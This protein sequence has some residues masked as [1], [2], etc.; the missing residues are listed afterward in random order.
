M[1]DKLRLGRINFKAYWI[2]VDKTAGVE[3][4]THLTGFI[5]GC[6][7]FISRR[8]LNCIPMQGEDVVAEADN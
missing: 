7:F 1:Q 3:D 4:A 6:N 8:T 2:A 5:H